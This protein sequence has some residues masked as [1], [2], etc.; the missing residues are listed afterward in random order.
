MGAIM[1]ALMVYFGSRAGWSTATF[2]AINVGLAVAW[3][4]FVVGI[5]KEHWRR[6]EEGEVA[7]GAEPREPGRL[8]TRSS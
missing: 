6:S 4:G 5:G 1:S 7:L 8:V 2:A 3:L